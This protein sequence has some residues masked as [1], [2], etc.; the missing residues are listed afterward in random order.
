MK[1][2][3]GVAIGYCLFHPYNENSK[4]DRATLKVVQKGAEKL[5]GFLI[6]Q[7]DRVVG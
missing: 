6:K 7:I 4:L 2:I 3:F 1:F 5:S